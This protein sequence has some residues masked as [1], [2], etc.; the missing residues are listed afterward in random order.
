MEKEFK[1][2]IPIDMEYSKGNIKDILSKINKEVKDNVTKIEFTGDYRSIVQQLLDLKKQIPTLDLSKGIEFHLADTIRENTVEGKKILENFSTFVINSLNNSLRDVD[3]LTESIKNAEKSLEDLKRTKSNL[4]NNGKEDALK[5]FEKAEERFN[6]ASASGFGDDK[7]N[8][9][10]KTKLTAVDEMRE[11][12]QDMLNYSSEAGKK[13]S[14]NVLAFVNAT[15]KSFHDVNGNLVTL[16]E[17]FQDIKV[18]GSYKKDLQDVDGQILIL[19]NTITNLKKSLESAQNPELQVK[20]KLADKF[21]DDLQSQLDQM[22]GLEVK[23]KPKVDKDVKLEIETAVDVKPTEI[24]ERSTDEIVSDTETAVKNFERINSQIEKYRSAKADE[25]LAN[26]SIVNKRRGRGFENI[27]ELVPANPEDVRNNSTTKT[28]IKRKLDEYLKQKKELETGVTEYGSKALTTEKTLSRAL[29]ELA[30]YTYSF[31]DAEEAAEI[32]G[33]KNKDVFDLVQQRIELAKKAAEGEKNSIPYMEGIKWML[34]DYGIDQSK[35]T[36]SIKRSLGEA[37]ETGGI[38]AFAAKVEELFGVKIPTSVEQAKASIQSVNEATSTPPSTSAMDAVEK[39]LHE[40]ASAHHE[41]AEAAKADAKAQEEFNSHNNIREPHNEYIDNQ[42][43][44]LQDYKKVSDE[45]NAL[46]FKASEEGLTD[47]E[48]SRLDKL[49]TQIKEYDEILKQYNDV[50]VKLKNGESYSIIENLDSSDWNVKKSAIK[51]IVFELKEETSAANE[52]AEAEPDINKVRDTLGSIMDQ[53]NTSQITGRNLF[54]WI[55]ENASEAEKELF[56]VSKGFE[57]FQKLLVGASFGSKGLFEYRNGA[58]LDVFNYN[59]NNLSSGATTPS[60]SEYIKKSDDEIYAS[61]RELAKNRETVLQELAQREIDLANQVSGEKK[62]IY[63][64]MANATIKMSKAGIEDGDYKI[65]E[66]ISSTKNQIDSL[67]REIESE[68]D[69]KILD[70]LNRELDETK[71]KFIALVNAFKQSGHSFSEVDA[72]SFGSEA[73]DRYSRTQR[74]NY[75]VGNSNYSIESES[76]DYWDNLTKG[77]KSENEL[78][79]AIEQR[80]QKLVELEKV[81]RTSEEKDI[82]AYKKYD[83]ITDGKERKS[84]WAEYQSLSDKTNEITEQY[85]EARLELYNLIQLQNNWG[86]SLENAPKIN[87][88]FLGDE[89]EKEEQILYGIDDE[90]SSIIEKSKQASQVP[91]ETPVLTGDTIENISAETEALEREEQQARKTAE[92]NNKLAE[93]QRNVNEVMSEIPSTQTNIDQYTESVQNAQQETEELDEAIDEIV[94]DVES[95]NT[96]PSPTDDMFENQVIAAKQSLDKL[97]SLLPSGAEEAKAQ[98]EQLYNELNSVSDN[99]GLKQWKSEFKIVANNIKLVNEETNA[100]KK[101]ETERAAAFVANEKINEEAHKREMNLLMEKYDLID[102]EKAAYRNYNINDALKLQEESYKKVWEIQQKI[103]SLDSNKN[104][105]EIATLQRELE[106]RQDNYDRA[107][108]LVALLDKEAYAYAHSSNLL[109]IEEEALLNIE[110]I[111]SRIIDKENNVNEALKGKIDTQTN[112]INN[113]S[114]KTKSGYTYSDELSTEIDQVNTQL[115]DLKNKL[116]QVTSESGLNAWKQKFDDVS[117]AIDNVNDKIKEEERLNKESN[118]EYEKQVKADEQLYAKRVA[119]LKRLGKLM[120]NS[121]IM[122]DDEWG[123]YI[124]AQ[125]NLV[126]NGAKMSAK[127]LK[128]VGFRLDEI[129]AKANATGKSGNTLSQMISQRTKSL[130]AYLATFASFY[131]VIGYVRQAFSTIAD[132]DT[133]LVDLRKTTHMNTTELND[134]YMSSSTIAK[135]LGVTT[136]EII[137]QAAAWSRLG[138]NTKEASET[139]AQLSSQFASISPGVSVENATDY[140]VSTMKAFDVV[141]DEV[142][143]TIMDNVNAIGNSFATTN[144]EIGEMLERSS[145]AMAAANN[146]LE[147]TIALESAAVEVTRNAE[148]TGTAFRTISMRIRG[149]QSLPPYDE[150]HMLY[151]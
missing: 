34:K 32:F 75:T 139:M 91:N 100:L 80:K 127:E 63:A 93:S 97:D 124:Q 14:D 41:N 90:I 3:F 107:D 47:K 149:K 141:T 66:K 55:K 94:R 104:K 113:K 20:G 21:L 1:I 7:K 40:E 22:T 145:A 61:G 150:N 78:A 43:K 92:S 23:V 30:A 108:H 38:E 136:S 86:K 24:L 121:G 33:K 129:E 76:K 148:T 8:V 96:I 17:N 59:K 98:L 83:S 82:E 85:N 134:F 52:A 87:D 79:Q 54:D 123:A 118:R 39:E 44:F 146:T 131:R 6:R 73:I 84:A 133:Q 13:I 115:S 147:E 132:L 116:K 51:D 70:G 60:V 99:E 138:Y 28:G 105:N 101:N 74:E 140:L 126:S 53:M 122:K 15:D 135:Q 45:Y 151:A 111:L 77:I 128:D 9:K 109:K 65:E 120:R 62:R 106:L 71:I 67:Q 125:F 88:S 48:E 56:G 81:R 4:L 29:D 119:I 69:P 110:R 19:E 130:V 25:R 58:G 50:R 26:P 37:I 64:D 95:F 18:T 89:W 142:E 27:S 49:R 103:A 137:Q 16:K 5:A 72:L 117:K 102:K 143:R 11:A 114:I 112:R 46:E 36:G 12:Y 31:K 42:I 144:G 68:T 57:E 35:I 2:H 10:N